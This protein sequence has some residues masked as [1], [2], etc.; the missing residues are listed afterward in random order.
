MD[1]HTG[2]Y[3]ITQSGKTTIA[4]HI[5]KLLSKN[6]QLI[7]FDPVGTPTIRGGWP[8]NAMIYN[9]TE[10]FLRA[11]SKA[12][13]AQLFIDEADEIFSHEQKENFWILSKGRHQGLYSHVI[14]QRPNRIHPTVRSQFSRAYLCRLNK[15][16][17]TAILADHGHEDCEINHLHGSFIMVDNTSH[18]IVEGNAFKL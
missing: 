17:R 6:H 7:V 8:D 1:Y 18:D 15:T 9:D 11:I 12:Q 5:A 10:Q 3:G 14:T 13:N 2:Y 4:R 16:D